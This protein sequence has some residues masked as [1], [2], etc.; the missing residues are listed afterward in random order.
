MKDFSGFIYFS[1]FIDFSDFSHFIDC[2][3]PMAAAPGPK[4]Q[5]LRRCPGERI[6]SVDDDDDGVDDDDSSD[7]DADTYDH[8]Q[9]AASVRQTAC[10]GLGGKA[11]KGEATGGGA[12]SL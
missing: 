9:R 11:R 3:N 5:C 12:G 6:L 7:G 4:I 2:Y 8:L 1:G 10:V